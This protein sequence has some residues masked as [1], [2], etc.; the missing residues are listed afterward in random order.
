[1]LSAKIKGATINS[2]LYPISSLPP[3]WHVKEIPLDLLFP[4]HTVTWY[5]HEL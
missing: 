2:L 4:A 1:M 5:A 3:L